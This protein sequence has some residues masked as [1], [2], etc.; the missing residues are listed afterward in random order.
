MKEL[1]FNKIKYRL[2][3]KDRN[4]TKI[5]T[6]SKLINT[7]FRKGSFEYRGTFTGLKDKNR[8]EIYEGDIV[9]CNFPFEDNIGEIIEENGCCWVSQKNTE[10]KDYVHRNLYYNLDYI[11]VIGNIYENPEL[12]K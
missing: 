7:T 5:Y 4:I 11:E 8:V 12:L 9:K 2:F 6:L 1:K 10:I 3:D